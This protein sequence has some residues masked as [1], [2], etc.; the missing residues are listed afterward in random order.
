M[1]KDKRK[2]ERER[3]L[4]NFAIHGYFILRSWKYRAALSAFLKIF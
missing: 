2:V 1:K 3:I 4:P